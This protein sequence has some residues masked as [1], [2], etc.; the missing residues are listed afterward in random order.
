MREKMER[1]LTNIFGIFVSIAVL[2]GVIVFLTYLVGMIIGGELGANLMVTAWKEWVP[3]FIR[4]AAIAV[5]AGLILFYV[6]GKHTLSL[7][8]EKKMKTPSEQETT[9]L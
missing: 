1:I 3:Y 8:E 4:S 6:T 2:G 7:K 9:P 5:L